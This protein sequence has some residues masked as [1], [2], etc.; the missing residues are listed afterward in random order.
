VCRAQLGKKVGDI[1]RDLRRRL[2]TENRRALFGVGVAQTTAN[3]LDPRPIC[4]RAAT[5]PAP[6]PGNPH[7]LRD[8]D[9]AELISQPRLAD[10]RLAAQQ[11]QMAVAAGR[12]GQ[13]RAQLG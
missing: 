6:P 10:S 12:I 4:G 2:R 3:D 8:R 9:P 11:E 1:L 5:L 13:A 7:A